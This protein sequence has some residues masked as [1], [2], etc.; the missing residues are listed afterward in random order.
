MFNGLNVKRIITE[1][2]YTQKGAIHGA[3]MKRETFNS[4]VSESGNPTAK[5]LE[6]IANFL[7]CSIDDFFDRDVE[8]VSVNMGHTVQGDGNKVSGNVSLNECHKEIEHLKELLTEKERLIQVL[9][10]EK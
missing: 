7:K 1:K 3:K 9:M 10:K 4:I 2:G 5:S 8:Y 6:T